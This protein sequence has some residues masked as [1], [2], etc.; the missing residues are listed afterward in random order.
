MCPNAVVQ[1]SDLRQSLSGVSDIS[2]L[3]ICVELSSTQHLMHPHVIDMWDDHAPNAQLQ[4]FREA[5]DWRIREVK[6]GGHGDDF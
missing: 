1:L 5:V 6:Q 4:E 2:H 3:G